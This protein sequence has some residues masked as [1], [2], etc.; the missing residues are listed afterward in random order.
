MGLNFL[1]PCQRHIQ[2]HISKE[3]LA[4]SSIDNQRLD[5]P[6]PIPGPRSVGRLLVGSIH[7]SLV[8]PWQRGNN[9]KGTCH[10]APAP[11]HCYSSNL[12]TKLAVRTWT[13]PG[14]SSI[15]LPTYSF[16]SKPNQGLRKPGV[17]KEPHCLGFQAL[18]HLTACDHGKI[19][20]WEPQFPSSMKWYRHKGKKHNNCEYKTLS[21]PSKM[22]YFINS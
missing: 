18:C 9:F 20:Y 1:R 13:D 19:I 10:T 11:W 3:D 6:F 2:L 8:L 7:L 14:C 16:P 22:S 4:H 5:P 17:V 15:S 21:A 12:W